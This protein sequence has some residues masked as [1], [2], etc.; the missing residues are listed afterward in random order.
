MRPF[1]TEGQATGQEVAPNGAVPARCS[2]ARL[3][4]ALKLQHK[5][6]GIGQQ[7][8]NANNDGRAKASRNG[9]SDGARTRDLRRDR[10]TL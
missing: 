8:W 4:G 10:P 1:G 6:E 9:G 2:L 7:D 5:S 3:P